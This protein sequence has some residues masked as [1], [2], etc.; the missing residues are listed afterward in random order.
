MDRQRERCPALC[1][2]PPAPGSACRSPA[3]ALAPTGSRPRWQRRSA[4]E[5]DASS[6]AHARLARA[7]E[8]QQ[9]L[10]DAAVGGDR[11]L[12]DREP[13]QEMTASLQILL[14]LLLE[15]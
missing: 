10:D 1:P 8:A 4:R 14:R 3:P 7:E 9:R 6:A 13:S 2:Q 5:G 11:D 12:V 15:L